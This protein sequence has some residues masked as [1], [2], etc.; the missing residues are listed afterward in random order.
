M[1]ILRIKVLK[2]LSGLSRNSS[3]YN[4]IGLIASDRS[5]IKSRQIINKNMTPI[6]YT[7]IRSN[8]KFII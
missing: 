8:K 4:I 6:E 7:A 1:K 2:I 3:S 5:P